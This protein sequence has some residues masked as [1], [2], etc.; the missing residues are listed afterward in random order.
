MLK[1][2]DV[3]PLIKMINELKKLLVNRDIYKI[4]MLKKALLTK[5]FM[6]I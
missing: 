5:A 3:A 1:N 6:K 4:F 2:I